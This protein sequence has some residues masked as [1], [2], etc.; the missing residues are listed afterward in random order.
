M[1]CRAHP[2]REKLVRPSAK[3]KPLR[4]EGFVLR[5]AMSFGWPD[6]PLGM[7]FDFRSQGFPHHQVF[8]ITRTDGHPK[9]WCKAGHETLSEGFWSGFTS[10]CGNKAWPAT[11]EMFHAGSYR[12][13]LKYDS[14]LITKFSSCAFQKQLLSMTRR[15]SC[16]AVEKLA[17]TSFETA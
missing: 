1:S 11:F 16:A 13:L 6:L 10:F 2:S 12:C 3:P 4:Y 17:Q 15:A 8:H 5:G 9:L 7:N 14:W